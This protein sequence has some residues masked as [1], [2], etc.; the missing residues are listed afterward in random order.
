[1]SFDD[2]WANHQSNA[3]HMQ[4]NQMPADRG[5]GGDTDGLSHVESEKRKAATYIQETL[6]PAVKK[7]GAKADTDSESVTGSSSASSAI[8]PGALDGW[9]TK[10]GLKHCLTEWDRQLKN[11]TNR[12]SSEMSALGTTNNLFRSNETFTAG[13]FALGKD[14]GLHPR[15][16]I[17]DFTGN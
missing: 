11:L 4:L 13:Q 12:L 16:N 17:S 15:S 5:S 10:A 1:M 3:T 8:S 2:E 14:N 6:G 7:A 9:E